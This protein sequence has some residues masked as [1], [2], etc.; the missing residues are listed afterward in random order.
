MKV[1]VSAA[2]AQIKISL[3]ARCPELTLAGH[4]TDAEEALE[5]LR[6]GITPWCE[7]LQRRGEVEQALRERCVEWDSEANKLAI[8]MKGSGRSIL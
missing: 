2:L 1:Y 6:R 3:E 5:S 8:L 7:R 4:G